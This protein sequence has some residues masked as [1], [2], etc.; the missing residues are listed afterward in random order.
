MRFEL[1]VLHEILFIRYSVNRIYQSDMD[2][3]TK[4]ISKM[5]AGDV[6]DSDRSVIY[7]DGNSPLRG[8]NELIILTL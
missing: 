6:A 3:F 8:N 4:D 5:E 2:Q 1:F 7:R